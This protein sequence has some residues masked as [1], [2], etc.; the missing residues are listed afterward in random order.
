MPP[1][2]L[3]CPICSQKLQAEPEALRARTQCPRCG[4]EFIPL[5]VIPRH[6]TLPA[7]PVI[8]PPAA[9]EIAEAADPTLSGAA[10]ADPRPDLKAG[11]LVGPAGTVMMRGSVGSRPKGTGRAGTILMDGSAGKRAGAAAPEAD[12]TPLLPLMMQSTRS[13]GTLEPAENGTLPARGPAGASLSSRVSMTARSSIVQLR[14][15]GRVTTLEIAFLASSFEQAAGK[16]ARRALKYSHAVWVAALVAGLAMLVIAAARWTPLRVFAGAVAA[17]SLAVMLAAAAAYSLVRWRDRGAVRG[18]VYGVS[19]E[20]AAAYAAVAARPSL[21]GVSSTA[22]IALGA[23]T[24]VVGLVSV[25]ATW[26][27]AEPAQR[28][29]EV[30]LPPPLPPPPEPTAAPAAAAEAPGSPRA[31]DKLRRMGHVFVQD[32]VLHAP[33]SFHSE[34]GAFDLVVHF[35]G[36][37]QLVEESVN[38]AKVN[39]LVYT[40]NLGIGSGAYEDR[41]AVPGVFAEALVRVRDMAEKRGL[42]DAKLRRVALSAWSAG[43]GAIAKIL[44]SKKNFERVDALLLLDGL[45]TSY[46]DKKRKTNPNPAQIEMF[47]RFAKE[48][49]EGKKLFTMTHSDTKP[50]EYASTLETSDAVLQL[51]GV[52]RA[53]VH[54]TP[55]RVTLPA[56][57]G[58]MGA[59]KKERWLEQTTEARKGG[60]HVRGYVGQTAENHIAHLVQMSVTVLPELAERW[61]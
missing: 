44:E 32:G 38:A 18:S 27:L 42:R 4:A 52:E 13:V 36:N 7:L 60:L 39:A 57:V 51:L 61:K 21:A 35:H 10:H 50:V 19:V 1:I 24:L 46:L 56:S 33:E 59:K 29:L 34:D 37:T 20:A 30:W 43:Y 40:V 25:G 26:L 49:A 23:C 54:E 3:N 8:R 17:L 14:A 28:A 15:S 31:D 45:H 11:P 53:S 6:N 5:D 47:T 12:R 41:Y 55:S 9:E 16:R 48:A 22:Q 2:H 58:V